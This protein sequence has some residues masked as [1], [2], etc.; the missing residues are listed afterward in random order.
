MLGRYSL[1][2]PEK[3]PLRVPALQWMDIRVER[4]MLGGNWVYES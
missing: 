3:D 2:V 1:A 4:T